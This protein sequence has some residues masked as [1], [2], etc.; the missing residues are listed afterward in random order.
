MCDTGFCDDLPANYTREDAR[1]DHAITQW[2]TAHDL[3]EA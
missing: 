3:G 1:D 2:E